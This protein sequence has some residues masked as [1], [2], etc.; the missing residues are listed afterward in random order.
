MRTNSTRLHLQKKQHCF[1][2]ERSGGR[3]LLLAPWA[4]S[5][6]ASSRL[7]LTRTTASLPRVSA[8]PPTRP[9][10]RHRRP[11]CAPHGLLQ[12]ALNLQ[13][14][15]SASHRRWRIDLELQTRRGCLD[16]LVEPGWEKLSGMWPGWR[17]VTRSSW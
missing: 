12:P 10:L 2:S 1:S 14:D 11:Q 13:H 3:G 9:R 8:E 17:R 15:K 7:H 6:L 4:M 16:V 5:I